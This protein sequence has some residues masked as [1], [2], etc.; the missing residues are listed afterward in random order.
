[1]EA[2][3]EAP[4]IILIAE[5]PGYWEAAKKLISSSRVSG[6]QIHDARIAA[7]CLDHG[8]TELLTADRDFGRFP[9]LPTRNPL[10]IGPPEKIFCNR[11]CLRHR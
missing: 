8:V 7:V 1:M 2:W 6:P 9:G 5:A 4:G 10:C 11:T 3:M